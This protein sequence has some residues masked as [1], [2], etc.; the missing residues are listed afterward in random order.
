MEELGVKGI[1]A[2]EQFNAISE[3]VGLKI[4]LTPGADGDVGVQT[5]SS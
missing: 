4:S 1:E 3:A 5:V 2:P